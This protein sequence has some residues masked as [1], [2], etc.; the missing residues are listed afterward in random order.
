M[1]RLVPLRGRYRISLNGR[2]L[3]TSLSVSTGSAGTSSGCD[4]AVDEGVGGEGRREARGML[5]VVILLPGEGRAR[6]PLPRPCPAGRGRCPPLLGRGQAQSPRRLRRCGLCSSLLRRC[7]ARGQRRCRSGRLPGDEG[8]LSVLALWVGGPVSVVV[9][10]AEG[11]AHGVAPFAGRRWWR[12]LSGSAVWPDRGSGIGAGG[13]AAAGVS[14]AAP[15]YWFVWAVAVRMG[16]GPVGEWRLVFRPVG[17]LAGLGGA[18]DQ[19]DGLGQAEGSGAEPGF[20]QGL[21]GRCH[22]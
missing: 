10:G 16:S 5:G 13:G 11:V 15:A 14:A 2:R 12:W 18:A 19:G 6:P 22:A 1:S 8:L 3:V 7:R 17:V 9:L 4:A 21:C 20:G